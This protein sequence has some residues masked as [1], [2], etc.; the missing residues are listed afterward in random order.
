MTR[1]L[2]ARGHTIRAAMLPSFL[3][4][5]LARR[6]LLAGKARVFTRAHGGDIE[7]LPGRANF[8]QGP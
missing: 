8:R 2:W 1:K 3:D 6:M 7:E 5:N 4:E